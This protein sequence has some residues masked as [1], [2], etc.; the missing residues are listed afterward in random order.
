[1]KFGAWIVSNSS[2]GQGD[3]MAIV[4]SKKWKSIIQKMNSCLDYS[5]YI[6]RITDVFH[7]FDLKGNHITKHVIVL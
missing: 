3:E 5:V 6:Q 2:S 4:L 7:N 1:M